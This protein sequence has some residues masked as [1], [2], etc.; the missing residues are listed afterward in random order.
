VDGDL[1]S[2]FSLGTALATEYALDQ[3]P[4]KIEDAIGG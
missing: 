1:S 4:K 3:L 2:A